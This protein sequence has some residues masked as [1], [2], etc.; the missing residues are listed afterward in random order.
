MHEG[1]SLK[2]ADLRNYLSSSRLGFV[3]RVVQLPRNR[4]SQYNPLTFFEPGLSSAL[5]A[6]A[7]GGAILA[8][9]QAGVILG[10]KV[11][12][13]S[14]RVRDPLPRNYLCRSI[15]PRL[16][17]DTQRAPQTDPKSHTDFCRATAGEQRHSIEPQ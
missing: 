5:S 16:M 2:A 12:S 15:G 10:G 6:V 9:D 7:H 8:V 4:V 11:V 3:C 14:A 17:G 1:E 13:N